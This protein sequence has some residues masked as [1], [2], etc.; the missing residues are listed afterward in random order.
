MQE[1]NLAL[2][3]GS[4][5][6]KTAVL[7]EKIGDNGGV[8]EIVGNMKGLIANPNINLSDRGFR[9]YE[10][11]NKILYGLLSINGIGKDVVEIIINNRPYNNLEDF[12]NKL[13]DSKLITPLQLFTLAKS[14]AL[15]SLSYKDRRGIMIELIEKITPYKEK[16]TMSNVSKMAANLPSQFNLEKA[17]YWF[18]NIYL[19]KCKKDDNN[20]YAPIESLE[21][22]NKNLDI[23]YSLGD[24]VVVIPIKSFEKRY[25]KA[26]VPLQGWL[27]TKEAL[28]LYRRALCRENW[29]LYCGG[30]FE[31]WEMDTI[32]FYSNRH[33]LD[34]YNID[35]IYKI[36][37][38]KTL[39]EFPTIKEVKVSKKGKEYNVY[40]LSTI[41]GTVV[42]KNKDKKLVYLLTQT[43]IVPLK[44]YDSQYKKLDKKITRGEGKKKITLD[45]SWFERGTKLIV[46]GYRK[47]DE[48]IP[49]VNN[50][51]SPVVK[52]IGKDVNGLK[53]QYDKTKE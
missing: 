18:R 16:L 35:S 15:D 34:N 48:F 23:E 44:F 13:V 30:T 28:D 2:K 17:Y 31:S 8:A 14:G 41:A 27:N 6:W 52:L 49:K 25:K 19:K 4:I 46:T 33:D 21:W 45:D 32:Y 39:S 5:F 38:F 26:I 1:L 20:F 37:D 7:S 40:D 12:Y 36:T 9:P 24:N 10:S 50:F 42:N 22:L 51:D 53:L 3:Y 43:G 11:E 47:L 29:N